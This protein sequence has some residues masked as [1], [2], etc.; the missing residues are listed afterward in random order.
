MKEN[1]LAEPYGE[2]V[3]QY[4]PEYSLCAGCTSCEIICSLVHDGL[5]SPSYSRI[6][7]IRGG[8]RNMVCHIASCQHCTDHPCYDACP[9]KDEAMCLDDKGIAYIREENCIGCGKCIKACRFDPPRIHMAKNSSRKKWKTKKCD[10]CRTRPEGP[11]CVQ[12]CPVRCLGVSK[13]TGSEIRN[14]K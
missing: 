3:V 5:V 4:S 8:T 9:K 14:P 1:R 6:S 2:H 7:L 10:L 11:A 13:D 12:Y